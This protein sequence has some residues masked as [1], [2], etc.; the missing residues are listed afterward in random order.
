MVS[1]VGASRQWRDFAPD[2]GHAQRAP[3]PR[4]AG[5]G[6]PNRDLCQCQWAVNTNHGHRH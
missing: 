4:F 6:A 3:I 5:Q 2:I 1:N